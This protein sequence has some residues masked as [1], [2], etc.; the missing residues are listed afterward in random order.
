MLSLEDRFSREIAQ[1]AVATKTFER[2]LRD[3]DGTSTRTRS[4][5]TGLE[6]PVANVDR[7]SRLADRSIN[8]LTGRLRLLT[9]VALTLGP[10]LVPLG[11]AGVAAVAGLTAQFGALAGGIGVAVAALNGVGDALKA[12]NE[13]QLDPTYDNLAKVAE[14]FNRIGPAGAEFVVF[15][16]SISP[17]LREMQMLAREGLLP[18][19]A[20]G[21]DAFLERGSQ[22]NNI[23]SDLATAVGDLSASAGQALGGDRFNAFFD[24]LDSDAGPLLLEFG[25]SVGFV[26][27]GLANML[28]AFAPA[29]SD[30]SSGLEDMTRRF[31]EWSAGLQDNDSFQEFLDYI[32]QNG[33]AAIDFL[34]SLVD[35]LASVVEAAAPIGQAVLPA[36]TA[37]LD[38]FAAIGGTTVG[39][40]L[41]A[42]AAGFV[43][44]NRA[45]GALKPVM[46]AATAGLQMLDDKLFS[47]DRAFD[48]AG[49]SAT[50]AGKKITTAMKFAGAV[51]AVVAL[52][53]ALEAL[54]KPDVDL[55]T[56]GR[57]L[58]TLALGNGVSDQL[59]GVGEKIRDF[60]EA[61]NTVSEPVEELT[62]GALRIASLGFVDLNTTLDTTQE[63]LRNIDSEL[64]TLVESGNA[65]TAAE[66]FAYFRDDALALGVSI[67]DITRAFPEYGKALKN[68]G[69]EIDAAGSAHNEL[70]GDIEYA[71][72]SLD[73]LRG[74]L[75]SARELWKENR[76]EAREVA[77]TFVNLGESLSDNKVSLGDW[78]KELEE[79]AEAL[80]QFQQNAEKAG[81]RGLDEGL[82]KSLQNAGS[83]GALRMRQL[84][85][86]TDEEIERANRA[87]YKGQGAVKDFVKEVGGVKPKYVTR[88]EAEVDQALAEIARLKQFLDIPDEYVNVWITR[89]TVDMGNPS[90]MGPQ[91]SAD[92]GTVPK[93]GRGYADRHLYLL[94]DGE[95]VISNRNGQADRHR[96]LLKAINAGRLADGGTAGRVRPNLEQRGEILG[97]QSTIRDLVKQLKETGKD[98]LGGLD[99]KIARNSLEQARRDLRDALRA[100]AREAR[101]TRRDNVR[102]VREALSLEADMAAAD[103]RKEYQE[104]KRVLR[105]AGI[106]LPKNFD[107]LR[108]K[109][110]ATAERFEKMTKKVAETQDALEEWRDTAENISTSVRSIFNNN[111]FGLEG[112]GL[113][114]ALLQLEADRN[115]TA[116]RNGLL[117][118]VAGIAQSLGLDLS[119]GAFQAIATDA[120]MQTL[121]DLD[122]AGEVQAF[123]DL[124]AS[125]LQEQTAAGDFAATAVTGTQI[126]AL[127]ATLVQ[128]NSVLDNLTKQLERQERQLEQAALNGTREGSRQGVQMAWSD[129]ERVKTAKAKTR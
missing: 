70:A 86:A 23:V 107:K 15:L 97:L 35:A 53:Q 87:W 59:D 33:P 111:I 27:E 127:E 122:T 40:S 2:T 82:V 106:D 42:A 39:A 76:Q 26:A 44:F 43:A 91:P 124:F 20:E 6:K 56:L 41:L 50:S 8:Q 101:Q 34:G 105:E 49:T 51:A 71:T 110:L 68:A 11:G 46:G 128:Q 99:R 88:L 81:R 80:R 90:G 64:A 28:V 92:G 84:A 24:Y 10:A 58:E 14:E 66:N 12:V 22:L 4:S 13:Y 93:T 3:L 63:G 61:M 62:T 29:S 126:A 73:S 129:Q 112:G 17:Q 37:I 69:S 95:E 100:P 113:A 74:A 77:E 123:F 115:D 83:E 54:D 89:R 36:L 94:A 98:A 48:T 114:N 47:I 57:D 121:R 31:A 108:E 67:E 96:S 109:S 19:L 120:D 72:T 45:A 38:V 16:E 55:A 30:F 5:V 1:A 65:E 78:L 103:I 116:E 25:R 119:S 79:N 117:Q 104:F 32:R 18:G 125:R 118:G 9:D 75:Q 60:S 102:N 21:I 85:N 52:G 7:N